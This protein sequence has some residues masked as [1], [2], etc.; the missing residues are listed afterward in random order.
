MNCLYPLR[1]KDGVSRFSCG[2]C[3]ACRINTSEMWSKRMYDELQSWGYDN[4][5]F[6]TLTYN[7]EHLPSN[8]SLVKD[9]LQR[10]F[11]RLRKDLSLF[12]RKIKCFA[13]GE[14][15]DQ[16][17]RPHYHAIIF[18][19]SPF[20][21]SDRDLIVKNWT[22]CDKEIFVWKHKGNVWLKGNAIDVVNERTFRY[23]AKY[24][25]KR[26][27][28]KDG[29]KEYI[30]RGLVPPYSYKSNGLGLETAKKQL[31]FMKDNG[32]LYFNG[33]QTPIPKYYRDK[34]GVKAFMSEDKKEA[35]R[36]RSISH[37]LEKT[38]VQLVLRGIYEKYI[39][40]YGSEFHTNKKLYSQYEK[41]CFEY[42]EKKEFDSSVNF[43][44]SYITYKGVR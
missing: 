9:E 4:A 28:G 33:K 22:F 14:Y 11:K 25:Q 18:G 29:E 21:Q 32:F 15:G 38:G 20:L 19:L 40:L 36:K 12:N 27:T 1:D 42:M 24:V 44:K 17:G 8:G 7:D 2:K 16:F 30:Q 3:I 43:E 37:Q 31:Q 5:C 23:V 34:F 26:L 10:F 13:C 41:E 39:S 35:F 6:V